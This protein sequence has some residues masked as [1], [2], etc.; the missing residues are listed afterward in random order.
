MTT[1]FLD[2]VYARAKG[3]PVARTITIKTDADV[4]PLS[5][6]TI[7]ALADWRFNPF[8]IEASGEVWALDV[9]ANGNFLR[10]EVLGTALPVER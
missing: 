10:A 4:R 9:D 7:C 6:Y 8:A 2:N 1:T 5:Y 3:R